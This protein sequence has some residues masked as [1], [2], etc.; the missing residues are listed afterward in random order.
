MPNK[1]NA[2]VALICYSSLEESFLK[3]KEIIFI[4]RAIH[5]LDPW[6][7]HC[8]LPGGGHEKKDAN[9]FDTALRETYEEVGLRKNQLKF[10][11][12]ITTLV[13]RKKI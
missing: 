9:Y 1:I 8:A 7:G 5:P 12:F 6:S 2:S 10:E 3:E 4:K 11:R 13:P